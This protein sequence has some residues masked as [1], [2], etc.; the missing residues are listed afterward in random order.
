[1]E[2]LSPPDYLTLTSP[3]IA[4]YKRTISSISM[5]QENRI[6]CALEPLRLRQVPIIRQVADTFGVLSSLRRPNKSS[7]AY[8]ASLRVSDGPSPRHYATFQ[9]A[10]TA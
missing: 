3:T 6:E 8:P 2:E 10:D 9:E 4:I 7:V 5:N 1:M